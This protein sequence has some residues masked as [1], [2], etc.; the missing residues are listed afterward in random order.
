M[1]VWDDLLTEADRAVIAKGQYGQKRGFGKKP[2]LLVIDLQSNYTG[3]NKPIE[4]QLDQWPSGAG[5]KAWQA[6]ECILKVRDSAR[7]NNIPIIYTRNVQQGSTLFDSFATKTKR[8]QTK[9]LDGAPEA[10]LLPCV[11]PNDNEV[12]INKGYA[13]A[14]YGTPLESYLTKLGVDT[15]II[16]GG[17]TGGCCR[18][19]AVDAVTRNYNLGYVEDCLY[20]RMEISHKIALLDVWMKYGDLVT[21]EEVE[22]YFRSLRG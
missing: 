19:T 2:V 9:Y 8:N 14:F 4:E 17:T 3:A 15:V 10:D 1:Y 7:E 13:S 12:V 21:G 5:E 16:V 6:L 11:Q 18:A 20:D 22:R